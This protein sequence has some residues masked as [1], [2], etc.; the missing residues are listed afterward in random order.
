VFLL[1]GL[2]RPVYVR[3][4]PP[5]GYH[6]AAVS[7]EGQDITDT[8]MEFKAD[9]TGKVVVRLTRRASSLSGEVHDATAP[10]SSL[11]LAFGED[12]VLWTHH[13]TTTKWTRSDESGK[14]K[15][16]GLRAG[17]YL[18]V[19]VPLN[20]GSWIMTNTNLEKWESLAKQATPVAIGDD[21]RKVLNLK[22]VSQL[23]R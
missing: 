9:T 8:P 23:D 22:L 5:D 15:L 18:V 6:L 20:S 10:A 21:E 16:S 1:K 19:A 12:R 17:N 14:Y 7:F 3:V 2:H 11:V 4:A 13:A